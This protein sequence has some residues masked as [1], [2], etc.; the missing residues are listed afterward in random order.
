MI[1]NWQMVESWFRRRISLKCDDSF[2]C[3][4]WWNKF[5]QCFETMITW[6]VCDVCTDDVTLKSV[7]N[8][9]TA[10]RR[11]FSLIAAL[12]L[13][14]IVDVSSLLGPQ[15]GPGNAHFLGPL[16][17]RFL[18]PQ[19]G[20]WLKFVQ[21]HLWYDAMLF[22]FLSPFLN[23]VCSI[24]SNNPG[25]IWL[26]IRHRLAHTHLVC[27]PQTVVYGNTSVKSK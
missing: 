11:R 2:V 24:L 16:L 6:S 8:P 23:R 12:L 14:R 19:A 15:F 10:N 3:L 5:S 17:N 21:V 1:R 25:N 9:Q 4:F 18:R 22:A 13:S 27:T 7:N 26:F 20:D